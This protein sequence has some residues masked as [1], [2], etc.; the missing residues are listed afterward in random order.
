MATLDDV[1]AI[2]SSNAD[3]SHKLDRLAALLYPPRVE[4]SKLE[5][6]KPAPMKRPAKV[7]PD[8]DAA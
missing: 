4:P 3:P 6:P 1:R 8:P 2:L 7:E 5:P